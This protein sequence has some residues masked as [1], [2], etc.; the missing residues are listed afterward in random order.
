[1]ASEK[2]DTVDLTDTELS[3]KAVFVL[4][5]QIVSLQETAEKEIVRENP[6]ENHVRC[7]E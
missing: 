7:C 4:A 3:K 5:A 6:N 2:N 1:V